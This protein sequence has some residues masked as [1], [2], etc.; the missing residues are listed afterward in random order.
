MRRQCIV[1]DLGRMSYADA[2]AIQHG[3]AEE[4][5]QRQGVDHLLFVEHPH[6]VTL[7]R[8]GHE[9]NVL[10]SKEML[11]RADIELYESDRGGDVTYHGPGQIVVYPIMDLRE[12]R[13]DVGAFV[14]GL[15]QVLID[16]LAGFGIH[17]RRI[18]KLI[19]VW[20]GE[21][22]DAAKIAAIGVHL[23]RWV[24]T[25]G[26]ALN[27]STDLR[28]FD[29]IVPCGLTKPVTSMEALGVRE[30]AEEV[31]SALTRCFGQVFDFEMQAEP[32]LSFAH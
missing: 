26:F 13:R 24:S 5:K 22:E 16:A 14:R 7:G 15:E 17:A 20:V 11:R 30:G 27:V 31:K 32:V 23:S 9:G 10:A 6:V 19:G 3:I 28:Y 25:H 8:D 12:W 1:R 29:Y 2:L 4:R 18:A 21:G